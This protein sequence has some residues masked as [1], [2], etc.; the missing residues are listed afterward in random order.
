MI[1]FFVQLRFRCEGSVGV[2]NQQTLQPRAM[3]VFRVRFARDGQTRSVIVK[4]LKPVIARRN[5][6]VPDRVGPVFRHFARFFG[7]YGG[8]PRPAPPRPIQ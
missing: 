7:F 3:R 2:L 1:N 5:E 6:L 8:R 4:R